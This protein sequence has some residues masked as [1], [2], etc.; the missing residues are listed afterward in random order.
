M[1]SYF[2]Y[3]FLAYNTWIK[4]LELSLVQENKAKLIQTMTCDELASSDVFFFLFAF[5]L[6]QLNLSWTNLTK[7]TI[8]QVI[9][10]NL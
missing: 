9:F 10:C 8:L 2:L 1:K 5:R 4:S 7:A 3:H 6:K